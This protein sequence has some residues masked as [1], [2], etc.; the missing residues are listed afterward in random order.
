MSQSITHYVNVSVS[1]EGVGP[2]PAGFGSPVFVTEHAL[3]LARLA[4]PFTTAADVLDAGHASGS[5]AHAFALA[6]LAQQPHPRQFYIGR[7]D[8]GDASVSSALD[9]IL[10]V[11]PGAWYAA[12][13]ESRDSADILSLAT[14][15][16]AQRKIALAQS[17]D[18]SLLSGAGPSFSALFGGTV[19]D[20]TY[21]LTFTGFGLVS[22]VAVTVTR[23]AGTPATIALLAA[24]MR[25]AL[26]TALGAGLAGVLAPGSIGGSAETVL[27]AIVDGLAS[28]T[29]TSSGTAVA[30]TA[31]LTVATV[32]ADVASALFRGQYT[33][34]ALAYHPT[35]TDRLDAA[36]LSRCLAF[37]LDQRKGGWAYKRLVGVEG[38]NLTNAQISA[39]RAVNCNY[40]AP[41]VS[42]AGQPIG[43]LTAQGWVGSGAAGAGRR[44]DVT[45]SLDYMHARLEEA[46]VDVLLRATHDV[47]FD[48]AGINQFYT[49]AR[50]VAG[51]SVAAGHLVPT[52]VPEG[53]DQAGTQTPSIIMPRYR[54]TTTTQR[55]SRELTFS[56]LAY[57]RSSIE[58]VIFNVEIRQ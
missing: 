41:A 28:G 20:G 26:T 31:D 55:V 27:F 23:T 48:D 52:I 6:L 5:P 17:N 40:F 47:P 21:I 3:E 39:L 36:W 16:E 13:I 43:A 15:T 51:R 12:A 38:T 45:T 32:D 22:P 50:R 56:M 44:I 24:D 10:A 1:L 58:R 14:W 54:D 34:T 11:N 2:Q 33:R 7:Q 29:V 49:A 18:A 4:G 42:S 9:A 53:E 30:S 8:S 57:L 19:A 25:T 37:D 35:D 46:L